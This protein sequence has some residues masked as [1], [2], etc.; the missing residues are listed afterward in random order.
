M[1]LNSSLRVYGLQEA[2]RKN[3]ERNKWKQQLA[4]KNKMRRNITRTGTIDKEIVSSVDGVKI[5]DIIV[6]D[7]VLKTMEVNRDPALSCD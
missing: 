2:I 5:K 7:K 3:V 6:G 1:D 4:S